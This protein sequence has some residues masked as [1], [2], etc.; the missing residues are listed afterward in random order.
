MKDEKVQRSEFTTLINRV[1]LM[2]KEHDN[3][4]YVFKDGAYIGEI[5]QKDLAPE[6]N[7]LNVAKR[8]I[9]QDES[10]LYRLQYS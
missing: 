7:L 5:E 3:V 9:K 1:L 2:K 10:Y 8:K 4:V 6:G